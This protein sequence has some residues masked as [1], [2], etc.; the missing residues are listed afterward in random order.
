MK[1]KIC[2]N[3]CKLKTSYVNSITIEEKKGIKFYICYRLFILAEKDS[4]REE[5]ANIKVEFQVRH[6]RILFILPLF[7][8]LC[9]NNKKLLR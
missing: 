6:C 3:I 4:A 7:F 9:I 2:G 8:E 5:E 1:R